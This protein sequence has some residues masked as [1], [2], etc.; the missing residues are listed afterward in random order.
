[1][2]GRRFPGNLEFFMKLKKMLVP[3]AMVF[4]PLAAFA[5][6]VDVS[7]AVTSAQ[8]EILAIIATVG[9][10]MIAVAVAGVGWRVGAKLV[11]RLG[12]AA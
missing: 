1:M 4:A 10:A 11:K 6:S 7:T 5:D 12:G 8:T 3:A 2:R 9:A